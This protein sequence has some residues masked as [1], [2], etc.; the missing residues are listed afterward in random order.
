MAQ[1]A[2]VV[3]LQRDLVRFGM[4]DSLKALNWMIGIMN[5]NN[6]YKRHDGSHY[7]YHLVDATQDLLNHGIRDEATITATILHDS[8]E[9]IKDVTYD[10]ILSEYGYDVAFT[11]QGVTKLDD[12]DYKQDENMEKYLFDMLNYWRMCLVKTSDRKHNFSTLE[13]STAKH[14]WRQVVE[15][16]KFFLSFFKEA[17]K[18]F[19]EYSSYFH[20]AKTSI[21][22]HLKRIKKAHDTE[23]KLREEIIE[24]KKKLIENGVDV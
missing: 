20:S 11:V 1:E 17:R 6:G 13:S 21:V 7:Y 10:Y 23:N 16:E 4:L 8:I 19:P 9:D 14:E 22:P 24:L 3:H 2:R 12:V 15:T 18:R 5:A